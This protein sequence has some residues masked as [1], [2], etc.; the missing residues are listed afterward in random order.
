MTD[1]SSSATDAV[2]VCGGWD[3]SELGEHQISEALIESE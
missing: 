1:T 2:I 3:E